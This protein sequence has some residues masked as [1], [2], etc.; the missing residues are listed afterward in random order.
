MNL[1]VVESVRELGL[2]VIFVDILVSEHLGGEPAVELPDGLA[3]EHKV[4]VPVGL[5][6]VSNLTIR[7]LEKTSFFYNLILTSFMD[8]TRQ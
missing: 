6:M 4:Q 7:K 1:Y 5:E 8:S 3:G 2:V